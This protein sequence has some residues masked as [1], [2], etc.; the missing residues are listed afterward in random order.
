MYFEDVAHLGGRFW[1]RL[2]PFEA[3]PSDKLVEERR[4]HRTTSEVNFGIGAIVLAHDV[5]GGWVDPAIHWLGDLRVEGGTLLG[6]A[7]VE[8]NAMG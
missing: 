2:R 3:A 5:D 7:R 8:I 6:S 1:Q 4:G